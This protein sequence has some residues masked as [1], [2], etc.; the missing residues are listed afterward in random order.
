MLRLHLP[1]QDIVS[2]SVL[3]SE[4]G[5]LKAGRRHDGKLRTMP[6]A[7]MFI[8]TPDTTQA[9]TNLYHKSIG[10]VSLYYKTKTVLCFH[11]HPFTTAMIALKTFRRPVLYLSVQI[12]NK[13]NKLVHND[14]SRIHALINPSSGDDN[15]V[16]R[17]FVIIV[18]NFWGSSFI[19]E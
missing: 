15:A 4:S 17:E 12:W 14:G 13:I 2:K 7:I 16:F 10:Q 11:K 6:W 9:W 3:I 1:I 5:A 19:K 18:S 8:R